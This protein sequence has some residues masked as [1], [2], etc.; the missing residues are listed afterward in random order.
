MNYI[1]LKDLLLEASAELQLY[2]SNIYNFYFLW[3]VALNMPVLIKS[4]YGEH[5]YQTYM[6]NLRTKYV[7]E[8]KKVLSNQLM[9]YYSRQRVKSGFDHTVISPTDSASALEAQMR[10]TLRSDMSRANDRWN[11]LASY[12]V[13]LENAT[14]YSEIS[15][16][17]DRINNT[18]HN[19]RTSILD[20]FPNARQ[21]LQALNTAS[22]VK[23]IEN[24]SQFVD[25]DVKGLL[26]QDQ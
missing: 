9:K 24:L 26:S 3:Y 15:T 13:K 7:S 23:Q 6:S 1:K 25:K 8:F 17:I 19:T 14:S 4:D 11:E 22:S 21:L 16:Y 10:L 18:V 5:I 2:P 12:V 20:K